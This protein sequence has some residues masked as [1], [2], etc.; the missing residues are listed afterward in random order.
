MK[1]TFFWGRTPCRLVDMCKCFGGIKR[2]F[3]ALEAWESN[4]D[5][6]KE[7][8]DTFVEHWRRIVTRSR[9]WT[10]PRSYYCKSACLRG[11]KPIFCTYAHHKFRIVAKEC[12]WERRE[13]VTHKYE[14]SV[15]FRRSETMSSKRLPWRKCWRQTEPHI[16]AFYSAYYAFIVFV[17]QFQPCLFCYLCPSSLKS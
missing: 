15:W 10:I 4:R 14:V 16:I 8:W 17:W 11:F 9:R 2:I 3:G 13:N 12:I 1:N 7:A 5:M 6:F